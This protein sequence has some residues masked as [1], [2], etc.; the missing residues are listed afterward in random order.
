MKDNKD[1]QKKNKTKAP[2]VKE[3]LIQDGKR[4]KK[5]TPMPKKKFDW[6]K[7]EEEE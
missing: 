1:K 7:L 4:K 5:L 3:D 2:V 6:R